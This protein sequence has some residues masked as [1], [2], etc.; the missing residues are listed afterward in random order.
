MY[1]YT[2]SKEVIKVDATKRRR[3]PYKEFRAWMLM[4]EV[5]SKD[6][7]DLLDISEVMVSQRLNGTGS[8]FRLEEIR[9]MVDEYGEEIINLFFFN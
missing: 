7:A 9:T 5:K 6:L 4:H 2:R 3:P 8:D 1:C